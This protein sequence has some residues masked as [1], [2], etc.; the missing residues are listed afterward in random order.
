MV[1]KRSEEAGKKLT[2]KLSCCTPSSLIFHIYPD[3][4]FHSRLLF[5]PVETGRMLPNVMH[6]NER[7][8][9]AGAGDGGLI[10]PVNVKNHNV[11]FVQDMI[12]RH[13][14]MVSMLLYF[15]YLSF[16]FACF[17]FAECSSSSRWR[18]SSRQHSGR[19][20]SSSTRKCCRDGELLT[21]TLAL[22]GVPPRRSARRRARLRPAP[23]P[24]AP[25]CFP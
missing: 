18:S 6:L 17:Y 5:E 19:W 20:R 15:G 8:L 2:G 3:L 23:L 7:M 12:P 10:P 1:I 22:T 11:V 4:I 25:L 21:L 14:G 16:A 9:F 13:S 24:Q